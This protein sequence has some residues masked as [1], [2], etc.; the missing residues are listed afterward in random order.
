MYRFAIVIL[1]L[2]IS[3]LRAEDSPIRQLV[4][5]DDWNRE[6]IKLPPGFA[7]D[8]TW[9]GTEQ[10]R[11][12]PGMMKPKSQSFFSYAFVFVLNSQ[13]SPDSAE[14]KSEFLKYYRG[15]CKA[16]LNGKLAGFDASDIS[17]KLQNKKSNRSSSVSQSESNKQ[18]DATL[19]W[20]EPFV[21]QKKQTLRLEI[22]V[23]IQEDRTLIFACV[24]PQKPSAEIWK[25]LHAIRDAYNRDR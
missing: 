6:T 5:P 17:L 18:Y 19:N 15:L 16:V 7:P 21:T 9:H 12:A 25:Q 11:F 8:M 4:A 20:I 23:W 14:I 10:I 3:P 2:A 24:S 13:K 22:S 1:F